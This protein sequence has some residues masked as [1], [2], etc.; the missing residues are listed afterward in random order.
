MKVRSRAKA[1]LTEMALQLGDAPGFDPE[2]ARQLTQG[3]HAYANN[4]AFPQ[5]A[6]EGNDS[7][8]EDVASAQY[9][10]IV[11]KLAAATGIPVNQIRPGALNQ[12]AQRM[13][14]ELQTAMQYEHGHEH[15]LEQQAIEI[16]LSLPEFSVA[17]E[18]YEAGEFRI[19]CQ[20]VRNPGEMTMQ[21]LTVDP[22]EETPEERQALGVDV[23]RIAAE[24]ESEKNKRRFINLLIQGSAMNKNYAFHMSANILN[25][26]NP[27]LVATYSKLMPIAEWIYWS[28][29]EDNLKEMM[30]QGGGHGGK[31]WIDWE[32]DVPVIHA[33]ALVFPVLLQ[34]LAKGLMEYISH[35]DD[36]DPDT[37][38]H[39]QNQVDTLSNELDDIRMGPEVWR[40]F[41]NAV[42]QEYQRYVPYI[43]DHLIKLPPG[44]FS[45][46]MSQ[47]LRNEP[48]GRQF[49]QGL[50]RQ[51]QADQQESVSITISSRL[52][53]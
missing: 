32:G 20:L 39:V 36:L 7:F 14:Q 18:P 41:L 6:E 51:M 12:L 34:E 17:R 1:M 3:Q 52:L 4:P 11:R 44:E 33:Q 42:G 45:L 10:E 53:E 43:Y 13:M 46:R 2:K 19:I 40:R 29:P 27:R 47:I 22:E 28:M 24:L 9:R 26:I 50:V 25:Q 23:E 31:A 49:I 16:L 8:A 38:R 15:E 30:R 5:R 48:A 21:G 35:A 37:Q